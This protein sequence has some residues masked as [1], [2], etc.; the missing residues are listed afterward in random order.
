[1]DIVQV[2]S[3]LNA[4][5][6][7]FSKPADPEIELHLHF[8]NKERDPTKLPVLKRFTMKADAAGKKFLSQFEFVAKKASS[9]YQ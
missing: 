6:S 5:K 8:V 1:V 3:S 7:R 2:Q 9:Y 4:L